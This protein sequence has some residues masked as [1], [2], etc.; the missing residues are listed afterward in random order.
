MTR[1]PRSLP[2]AP[3][4]HAESLY[5]HTPSGWFVLA[6]SEELRPGKVLNK[7]LAGRDVVLW[8]SEAGVAHA[9]DPYCPH[10]GAHLGHGG[11]VCG[12]TIECPFHAFRFSSEGKCVATG[13]GTPPPPRARLGTWHVHETHGLVLVWH[14]AAG[15]EPSFRVPDIDTEG[16]EGPRW[17]Q[18]E[19][20][21]HPQETTENSVDSGHLS[22]VHGYR[23]I[24]TKR[25]LRLEGPHLS[26]EYTM[27]RPAIPGRPELGLIAAEFFIHVW[28][29]GYSRVEVSAPRFGLRSRHLVFATPIDRERLHMRIGFAHQRYDTRFVP[30]AV[31]SAVNRAIGELAIR[32]FRHDVMQDF[33]IWNY[34][35]YVHPPQLAVGDGPIGAYRRWC[36][37]FYPQ[38]GG[39]G[40][41]T[42]DTES[43]SD[44]AE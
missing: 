41:R 13:Y 44:A 30:R 9:V 11:R 29:L 12:E 1:T 31:V 42:P 24:T 17:S 4:D 8:R 34:K 32:T 39:S 20:R 15:E 21:G 3:R 14:G 38:L 5:D 28:G 27:N 33:D 43:A 10:M 35:T 36:K 7:R 16:W 2:L 40:V 37:Q 19:M 6:A 18:W 22:V 23:D 25:E 26:V